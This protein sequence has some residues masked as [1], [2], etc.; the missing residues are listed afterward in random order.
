MVTVFTLGTSANGDAQQLCL[1]ARGLFPNLCHGA[2]GRK[3]DLRSPRLRALRLRKAGLVSNPRAQSSSPQSTAEVFQLLLLDSAL[4]VLDG[5]YQTVSRQ[6]PAIKLVDGVPLGRPKA[7]LKSST[8]VQDPF[9]VPDGLYSEDED[10]PDDNAQFPWEAVSAE[11]SKPTPSEDPSEDGMEDSSK[12]D[13]EELVKFRERL[14]KRLNF[15]S[16]SLALNRAFESRAN[17]SNHLDTFAVNNDLELG[18]ILL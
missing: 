1:D 2:D 17:L 10:S 15:R 18:T 13:T 4:N 12:D 5:F 6:R 8:R 7:N 14:A 11:K 9:I 16:R 3:D